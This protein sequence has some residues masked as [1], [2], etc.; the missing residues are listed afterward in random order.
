MKIARRRRRSVPP[1]YRAVP[2]NT[3]FPGQP[4]PFDVLEP[5]S[6]ILPKH[7][8]ERQKPY[9]AVALAGTVKRASQG[10]ASAAQK[11]LKKS[12]A[13]RML[14]HTLTPQ[15][16]LSP[17]TRPLGALLC[18]PRPGPKRTRGKGTARKP[19]VPWCR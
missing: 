8:S 17:V 11:S 3:R 5:F 13:G 15:P 2:R 6:P 19:F 7:V 16:G 12:R 14:L 18:K 1:K 9:R 10:A 4:D